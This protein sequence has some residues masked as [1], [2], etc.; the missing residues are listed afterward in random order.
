MSC[1]QLDPVKED[2]DAP[3]TQNTRRQDSG[4]GPFNEAVTLQTTPL[5]LQFGNWFSQKEEQIPELNNP[6]PIL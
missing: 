5:D 2:T 4:S 1:L 6:T 3:N